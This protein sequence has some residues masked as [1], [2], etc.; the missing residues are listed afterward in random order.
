[1]SLAKGELAIGLPGFIG[2]DGKQK[3]QPD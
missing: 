3:Q 1:V 2:L